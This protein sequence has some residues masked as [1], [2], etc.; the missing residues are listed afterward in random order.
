MIPHTDDFGHMEGDALSIK[1]KVVPMR[2]ITVEEVQEDLDLM[3][4]N[5]VIKFYEVKGERYIEIINFDSFQ[6]FRSDRPRRAEHPGID[7]NIPVDTQ[8]DTT[9]IPMVDI[10]P[11]KVR[12]GKGSKGKGIIYTTEFESFWK[13]YPKKVGKSKTFELW[14]RLDITEKKKIFEDIPKRMKDEKWVAGF[15]K[16]PERYIKNQQWEDQIIFTRPLFNSPGSIKSSGDKYIK[17]KL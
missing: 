9:D 8:T 4:S 7:G 10:A 16:D 12:E 1:A 17:K 5:E 15:I 11:H 14:K 6:T 2:S 13:I 3:T